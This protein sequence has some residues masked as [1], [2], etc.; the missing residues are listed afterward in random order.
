LRSINLNIADYNIRLEATPS[1]PDL[2]LSERFRGNTTG[3]IDSN[4]L[5]RV[6]S[7]S[8]LIPG[9]A[10]RMF[11]APYVEEVN[12]LSIK[13]GEEFWS[14]YKH[15][16]GLYLKSV[17]PLSPKPKSAI[18]RFSLTAREWDLF[19]DNCDER[20]DPLEYPIDGLILYYLTIIHG[21]IFIHASGVN[22]SGSGYLFSGVSGKG[23]TTMSLLWK[24]A[25]ARIIHDDRLIIRNISGKYIMYNTPVYNIDKPAE[26]ALSRIYLIDHG[27]KNEM[28]PMSGAAAVSK[29]MA[30]CIQ[31]NWNSAI[32]ARLM[33]SV[34]I[35]CNTIPV[36]QLL[37]RPDR[38]VID[39]LLDY[40]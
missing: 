36:I 20:T 10:R 25:G 6:H 5:I 31:H 22:H 2:I 24:M 27:E 33:G 40:E 11:H 14:I 9:D 37:F 35:M 15:S 4:L 21:D 23:K 19:I 18:L 1:G 13:K 16:S 30:N 34:S 28:I 7:S 17:L 8:Y 3:N 38:T 32:I 29:V 12:G 26:S 39:F